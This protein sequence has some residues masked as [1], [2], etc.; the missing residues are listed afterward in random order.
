MYAMKMGMISTERMFPAVMPPKIPMEKKITTGETK[1]TTAMVAVSMV[2][3]T[4]KPSITA[5]SIVVILE[6][7]NDRTTNRN[8]RLVNED[9]ISKSFIFSVLIVAVT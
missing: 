5:P 7:K 2:L 3:P 6:M 1:P 8:T 9:R 4:T